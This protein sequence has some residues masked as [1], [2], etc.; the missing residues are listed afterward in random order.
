MTSIWVIKR[1]LGRSWSL[2]IYFFCNPSASSFGVSFGY[3]NTFSQGIWSS[4][5]RIYVFQSIS[6]FVAC[7]YGPFAKFPQ[8]I[9]MYFGVI[10]NSAMVVWPLGCHFTPPQMPGETRSSGDGRGR[11]VGTES[12]WLG[13]IASN[14]HRWNI[15]K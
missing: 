8:G 2:F 9:R 15:P 5:E 14:T 6:E 11:F 10:Q 3:L 12:K 7:S 13:T 1:S 4:R